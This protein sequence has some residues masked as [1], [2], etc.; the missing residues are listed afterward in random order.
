MHRALLLLLVV[1][2]VV[3]V[4]VVVS[5]TSALFE[6]TELKATSS[7]DTV[8]HPVLPLCLIRRPPVHTDVCIPSVILNIY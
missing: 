7:Q 2:V 6:Q 1:I 3:V 5:L 8:S 4:V